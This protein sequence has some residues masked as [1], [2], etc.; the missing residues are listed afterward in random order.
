MQSSLIKI[1]SLVNSGD[2]R[3]KK[4]NKNIFYMLFIKGGIILTNLMIVPLTLTYVDSTTY[5][6]WLTLSSVISWFSFFEIGLNHG[7]KNRLA[8]A[9]A[10]GENRKAKEYVSTTYAML[11]CIFLPLML[12]LFLIIP[13]ID[14]QSFL[15][16]N[17][18][19][20]EG[21]MAAVY[22]LVAYFCLN[23]ILSSINV[24]LTA[25]Q[26]PADSSFRQLIHQ[27]ISILF[28]YILTKITDGNIF[29][30]CSALCLSPLA[31]VALFNITLFSKRYKQIA[32]SVKSVN[33]KCLPSL[34]KLGVQFFVIQ[35]A[36]II[37]FQ[38]VNFLIIR[39]YGATEVTSYNIASKYFG[40]LFMVWGI[41]ITPIW[42]AVTDAISKGDYFWIKTTL[43]RYMR[44]FVLF[45]FGALLMLGVSEWVYG[46]WIG[47]AVEIP[48]WLSFWIMVYNVVLIFGSTFVYI[49]NGAGELK[50]QTIACVI[51]PILFL[52]I[53]FAIRDIGVYSIIIGSILANFN[54]FLLAPIQCQRFIRQHI[55]S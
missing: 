36:G 27:I 32:P 8:E 4:V 6:I 55:K 37:Q 34:M 52:V 14:W 26:R 7:L 2:E 45:S 38:M 10:L 31:V 22:V 3:S 35:I 16:I 25:D 19:E 33:F 42:A 5:G 48:F 47:D 24:V 41:L 53:V 51:S 23:F 44:L 28:I 30:L 9:L 1:K 54:G 18:D 49:L 46:F 13:F 20:V 15:H 50:I 11:M 29:N 17:I 12:I 21:F 39:N 40:I 43:T